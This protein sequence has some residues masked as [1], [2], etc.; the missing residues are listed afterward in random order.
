MDARREAQ[1]RRD[2]EQLAREGLDWVT[3]A[4]E[5]SD[6]IAT[7]VAF[8][9][10]CWH[11]VDPGTVLFTGS[12]NR[13][14]GCSGA[15]LAEHEY[16]IEDVNKWSFLAR[17]GRRA[18][19]TGLATHGDLSRSA[20]HRSQEAFGIGD[21]LRGSFVKGGD[22]WG[23]A[24][25]LRNQGRDHFSENDVAFLAALSET[26]ADGVRRALVARVM[27]ADVVETGDSPGIVLFDGEGQ[28][29]MILLVSK[30]GLMNGEP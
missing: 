24:G 15:W 26:L 16:V 3:L 2:I 14:I 28:P 7:V 29:E 21:E 1:V 5:A 27:D 20:R 13:D 23:A 10:S 11:T 12:V 4:S 6:L 17:S 25:F 8:D 22:Y 19:A 30:A 18:G 9:R